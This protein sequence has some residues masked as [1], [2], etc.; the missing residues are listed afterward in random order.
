MLTLG[1]YYAGWRVAIGGL[2]S[3]AVGSSF[4]GSP[5]GEN[6]GSGISTTGPGSTNGIY[7]DVSYRYS[8]VNTN[9]GNVSTTND[10]YAHS[11][12]V[13]NSDNTLSG[14]GMSGNASNTNGSHI[15]VSL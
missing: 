11:G 13:V 10:Q 15:V 6:G 9:E 8:S 3:T 7:H 12:N 4:G 5:S 1:R 2:K 14:N